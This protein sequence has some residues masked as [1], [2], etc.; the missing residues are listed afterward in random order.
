MVRITFLQ[1]EKSRIKK[2]GKK[3]L[4]LILEKLKFD[5]HIFVFLNIEHLLFF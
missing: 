2:N 4:N 3:F 1:S 5:F